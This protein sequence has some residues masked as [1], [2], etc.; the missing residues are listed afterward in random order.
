MCVASYGVMPQ[1]Y[2]RAVGAVAAGTSSPLLVSRSRTG[3]AAPGQGG[4]GRGGPTGHSMK[5]TGGAS[6]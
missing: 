6:R 4:Q 1:T 2:M 5:G 3:A